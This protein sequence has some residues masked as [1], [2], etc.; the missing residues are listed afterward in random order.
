MKILILALP[1]CATKFITEN[2]Q[3]YLKQTTPDYIDIPA[4]YFVLR[5]KDFKNKAVLADGKIV[6]S[7][8]E[9]DMDIHKQL[10]EFHSRRDLLESIHGSCVVKHFALQITKDHLIR[11]EALF[12][13]VYMIHRYDVFEQALSRAICYATNNYAPTP[14]QQDV[15]KAAKEN[16]LTLNPNEFVRFL[17]RAEILK[18]HRRSYHYGLQFNDLV[19]VQNA[20]QFCDLLQIPQAEFEF[21]LPQVELGANKFEMVENIHELREAYVKF[22][23]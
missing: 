3:N 7:D 23:R 17:V 18:E 10:H 16:K 14:E 1:R 4:E 11:L 20:E 12:H 19:K 15:I 8:E 6:M 21:V 5:S 2:L 22:Y 13:R 9:I